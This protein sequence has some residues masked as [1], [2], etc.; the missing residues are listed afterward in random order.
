MGE[1]SKF[2]KSYGPPEESQWKG[3][4]RQVFRSEFL[5]GDYPRPDVTVLPFYPRSIPAAYQKLQAECLREIIWF[6][7]KIWIMTTIKR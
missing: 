7:R 3:D 6:F 2:I 1:R 5:P 4:V